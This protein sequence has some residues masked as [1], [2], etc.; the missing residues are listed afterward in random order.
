MTSPA[1]DTDRNENPMDREQLD[2]AC[3][4][5]GDFEAAHCTQSA[6]RISQRFLQ[7]GNE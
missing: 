7:E 1:S 2:A 3:K 5:I 4:A 6:S